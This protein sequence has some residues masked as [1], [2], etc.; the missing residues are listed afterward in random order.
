MVLHREH[1]LAGVAEAFNGA[2]VQVQMRNLDPRGQGIRV[3]GEPMI[4][5]C[6]LNLAG[7]ELLHRMVRTAVAELQFERLA[8]D[9]K[10]ENLVAE[11]DAEGRNIGAHQLTYVVDGVG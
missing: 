7:F 11:T 8:A 1:R 3:D 6:N 5:G 2:V 10:P 4:L 9:R